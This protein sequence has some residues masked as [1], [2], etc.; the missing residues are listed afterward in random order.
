MSRLQAVEPQS[1][2]VDPMRVWFRFIRLHRRVS[3]AV[4]VELRRLGLSIPQF[5]VLSTLTESEGL[6]QQDLAARLYVTKGNVSGLIDRLVEAGLVERRAIPGD[7]RSHALHLT[8]EGERLAA[9]GIAA[10][11]AYVAR[12]LGSLPPKDLAEFDRLVRIWRDAARADGEGP[13]P[14]G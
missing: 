14:E 5:D 1:S 9:A 13:H 6:T 12:T 11:S 4:G 10:Q 2:P 8:P 3:N 7:R